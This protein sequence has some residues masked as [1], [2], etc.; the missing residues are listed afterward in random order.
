MDIKG[1]IPFRVAA[2][3]GFT[4]QP[5][6]TPV[7]QPIAPNDTV[8]F[9][10]SSLLGGKVHSDINRGDGFDGDHA[11]PT[12]TTEASGTLPLYSRSAEQVEAATRIALGRNLDI[13][14]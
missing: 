14:G 6:T 5:R 7:N 12:P 10:A 2:A 13:T 4:P 11:N 3:Y 9:D 1:P 8:D